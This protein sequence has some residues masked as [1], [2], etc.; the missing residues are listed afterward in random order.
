M[1]DSTSDDQYIRTYAKDFAALSG[2]NPGVAASTPTPPPKPAPKVPGTGEIEA[3]RQALL[4][5]LRNRVNKQPAHEPTLVPGELPMPQ[6]KADSVPESEFKAPLPP[7][8]PI[9]TTPALTR[10][11]TQLAPTAPTIP[12]PVSPS[13][14]SVV[15]PPPVAAPTP[16]PPVAPPPPPPTP[17]SLDTVSP[18][19]T[20]TSDFS[21]RIDTK[22][23]SAF[24]VLAAEADRGARSAP[25]EPP[26]RRG[27]GPIAIALGVVLLALGTG[28]AYGAYWYVSHHQ[29]VPVIPPVPSLIFADDRQALTGEGQQLIQALVDSAANDPLPQ[30][31]VRV[32][33]L[34]ESSTTP[35]GAKQEIPL[36]GGALIGA[37]QLSAPDVLLRNIGPESTVGIVHA[38]DETRP[39]FIL[40][41]LSYES[42]F[43]GML[44]WEN[45]MP[46]ALGR[47]YPAYPAPP[48]PAPTIATTTTL[49]HGKR[50][51]ATTTIA[52]PPII[53]AAPAFVDEVASNH[54]VRAFKD[55]L[56]RTILLYG[57][58][59][60]STLVI[61]RDEA[62]FAELVNRLSATKQQ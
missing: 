62:A 10:S 59:D 17:V 6:P 36:S 47:L 16:E 12:T 53:L 18:I 56:G 4:T 15:I 58:V 57:Y 35:S 24:S 49:V 9:P 27:L 29:S 55:G 46:Y 2:K 48:P 20:Y 32:V 21:D 19:H 34:T 13:I 28:G 11:A 31:N 23:A 42:T 1:A 5:R 50:V 43:A 61:A 14:P 30:G 44:T 26:Q 39:F 54:D 33:Y 41:V 40:K 38:G 8:A 7:P 37:L 52:A 45:T 22:G 60:K 25:T 3:D 51:V